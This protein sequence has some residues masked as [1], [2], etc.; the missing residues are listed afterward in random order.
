MDLQP[1]LKLLLNEQIVQNDDKDEHLHEDHRE[2]PEIFKS[3]GNEK[4]FDKHS[5]K[6]IE[7]YPFNQQHSYNYPLKP[8]LPQKNLRMK[9]VEESE[10]KP[11]NVESKTELN[12]RKKNIPCFL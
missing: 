5:S 12:D 9:I 7:R 1:R 4:R 11:K 2:G 6:K 8:I 3:N 10:K